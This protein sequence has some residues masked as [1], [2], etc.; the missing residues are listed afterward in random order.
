MAH[1]ASLSLYGFLSLIALAQVTAF[2][3]KGVGHS[4]LLVSRNKNGA[5]RNCRRLVRCAAVNR[6]TDRNF[7]RIL[8]IDRQANT[9]EIKVAYRRLAKIYHPGEYDREFCRL[10]L[11]RN[12]RY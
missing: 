1:Q 7:Y 6:D 8:Q 2:L 4:D 11:A 3:S 5:S 10:S 9:A 12:V